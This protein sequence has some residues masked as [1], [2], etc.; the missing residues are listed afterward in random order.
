MAKIG[1]EEL[2]CILEEHKQETTQA[3]QDIHYA[4]IF[5]QLSIKLDF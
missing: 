4:W 1:E 5:Q 2:I 3:K